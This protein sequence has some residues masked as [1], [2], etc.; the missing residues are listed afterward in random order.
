MRNPTSAGKKSAAIAAVLFAVA[1]PLFAA[2]PAIT[3]PSQVDIW[4]NPQDPG[5][6]TYAYQ[7][8]ATN[9][10]TAYDAAGLPPESLVNRSTGWINGNSDVPGAYVVTVR[11]ANADGTSAETVH[12]AIHPAVTGVTST[13]GTYLA[14]QSFSFT[15]HYNT[16]VNVSGLPQLTIAIGPGGAEQYKAASYISGSGTTDLVFGY[17]VTSGDI[18]PDGVT[19]LPGGPTGGTITDA[20]GLSAAA[21]LPLRYF[22][23]GITITDTSP[24]GGGSTTQAASAAVTGHLVNISARMNVVDGD[25]NRLL[26]AG[27]VITGNNAK[28]VLARAIGPGLSQFG[29]GGVLANPSLSLYTSAGGLAGSND[30]WNGTTTSDAAASVG[31]FKLATG[32]ADAATVATLVPGAYTLVVGANGGSG[33]ALAEL[34]DADGASSTAGQGGPEIVN[35]SVR[36]Q[37]DAGDG[38]LTVGFAIAGDTPRRV[39]VRAIGPGLAPFGVTGTIADPQLKVYSGTTVVAQNDNWSTSAD[40][41]STASIQSGAFALPAGSKDAAVVLTLQ[42]GPYTAAVGGANG[43]AGVGLVEVYELP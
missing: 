14:G 18:D 31:A 21:T 19:L 7:I 26:V 22:T 12:L 30:N 11:A 42:P 37:I 25:P 1:S 36:A 27:F 40:D 35:L 3:S 8:V 43:T 4:Y 38:T 16:P 34:Y 33:Q 17:T 39:L 28:H 9:T 32:S 23:S 6:S 15:L 41:V 13:R 24:L 20:G 10:P 5:A 29:V 2:A